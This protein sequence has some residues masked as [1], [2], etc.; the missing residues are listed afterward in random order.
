MKHNVGRGVCAPTV[1]AT[2]QESMSVDSRLRLGRV[3][4]A[5]GPLLTQSLVKS[6][7][8]ETEGQ[9]TIEGQALFASLSFQLSSQH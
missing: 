8:I 7:K 9:V 4:A 1:T 6:C 3:K 2:E 5:D